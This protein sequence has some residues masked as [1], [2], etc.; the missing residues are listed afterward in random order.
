MSASNLLEITLRHAGQFLPFSTACVR[1]KAAL[2][3]PIEA[4]PLHKV[5]DAEH[6]K[7]KVQDATDDSPGGWLEGYASVFG[8][9]DSGGD[10]VMKGAFT[11]TLKERLKKGL[12]KM[13]DSHQVFSM[14]GGGTKSIIGVVTEAKEDDYGLWFRAKLSMV[15]DAQDIRTKVKEGILTALSFGYDVIKS[16]PD[17]ND[18]MATQLKELKLYEISVVPW[19]MNELAHLT[20]V[21]SVLPI[22]TFAIAEKTLAFDP[23]AALA[24]WKTFVSSKETADWEE[25]EWNRFKRGFLWHDPSQATSTDG[26]KFQVVDVVDGVPQ[27]VFKAV[28]L[29]VA[30]KNSGIRAD[31]PWVK[32]VDAIEVHTKKLYAKF[33]EVHPTVGTDIDEPNN[34]G[35]EE[36]NSLISSMKSH[37]GDPLANILIGM[38]QVVKDADMDEAAPTMPPNYKVVAI[39]APKRC[40][41]C[42]AFDN[43]C[44][45]SV[46]GGCDYYNCFV[47]H[48]GICDAFN[49]PTGDPDE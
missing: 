37:A 23:A 19:G 33:G 6:A 48:Q 22:S 2:P 16:S 32:D 31:G 34:D 26:Y 28:D 9:V 1:T 7:L 12:I 3:V 46:N 35:A 13:V 25:V 5:L 4:E 44:N 17:P 24:R 38:K 45:N 29:V 10:V 41:T 36:L 11:K 30:W 14:F 49:F 27:Y 39:D 21:K 47:M 20:T 43:C 18:A 42:A 15:K 40:A 8:N